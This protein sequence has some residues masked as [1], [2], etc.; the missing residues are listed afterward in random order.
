MLLMSRKLSEEP[1]VRLVSHQ[2]PLPELRVRTPSGGTSHYTLSPARAC[3]LGAYRI[4]PVFLP[5]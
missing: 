5:R 2:P 4:G 3:Y 1:S